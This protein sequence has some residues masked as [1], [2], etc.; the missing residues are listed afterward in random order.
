MTSRRLQKSKHQLVYGGYQLV[1]G[2]YPASVKIGQNHIDF[3]FF[4][5]ENGLFTE[6][7]VA[8]RKRTYLPH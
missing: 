5:H 6:G 7:G 4:M 3:Y 2:G 1:Y 8:G